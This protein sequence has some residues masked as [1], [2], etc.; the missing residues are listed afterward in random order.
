MSSLIHDPQWYTHAHRFLHHIPREVQDWLFDE[1][2]LTARIIAAC[3]GPFR[4][5]IVSQGWQ[6]PFA[7]EAKRL[8]MTQPQRAW[9]RQVHLYCGD[10]PWVFA[11]TVVPRKTLTGA[12]RQLVGL[13][14]KSLGTVLFSDPGMTRDSMEV[15]RLCAPHYFY[16]NATQGLTHLP[17]S[18]WGRRSVFYLK[19]KPLLVNEIFLPAMK[20][21]TV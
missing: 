12:Q 2:S 5:E 1:G 18:V 11:R 6:R 8:G 13:G 3:N 4:V 10:T 14:S 7:N 15:A 9:V 19:H 16:R 20:Y 21:N 17:T